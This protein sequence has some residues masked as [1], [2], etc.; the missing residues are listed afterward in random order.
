MDKQTMKQ[1]NPLTTAQNICTEGIALTAQGLHEEALLRYNSVI[2]QFGLRRKREFMKVIA[3]AMYN[4]GVVLGTLERNEEAVAAYDVLI[5]QSATNKPKSVLSSFAARAMRNKAYRLNLLG[6]GSESIAT[7]EAMVAQF[8]AGTDPEIN[9]IVA[10]VKAFLAE[11][12]AVLDA[13]KQ[14][15]GA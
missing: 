3:T 12:Q 11:R 7:Y 13:R 6:R 9:E 15:T 4:K 2:A 8:G 14:A 10:P 1:Q 5:Q